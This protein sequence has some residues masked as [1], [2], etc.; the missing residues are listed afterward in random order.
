MK[1]L[2]ETLATRCS[3]SLSDVITEEINE[4]NSELSKAKTYLNHVWSGNDIIIKFLLSEA[5]LESLR[6]YV[7]NLSKKKRLTQPKVIRLTKSKIALI[8]DD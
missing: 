1:S 7:V 3:N 5:E 4:S 6:K 2:L 8:N